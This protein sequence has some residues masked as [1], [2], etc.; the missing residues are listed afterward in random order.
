VDL[1]EPVQEYALI[2]LNIKYQQPKPNYFSGGKESTFR[3]SEGVHK[4]RP[5]MPMAARTTKEK[6]R[7]SLSSYRP[8]LSPDGKKEKKEI[9]Y[10][11]ACEGHRVHGGYTDL[12]LNP[13]PGGKLKN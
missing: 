2:V 5:C 6:I 4:Q 3:F 1:R 9:P 11:R 8:Q 12:S 10:K 13:I 7:T